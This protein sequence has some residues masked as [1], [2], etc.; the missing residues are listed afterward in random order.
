[1]LVTLVRGTLCRF[2]YTERLLASAH[3]PAEGP[4]ANWFLSPSVRKGEFGI[5]S[6]VML[7]LNFNAPLQLHKFYQFEID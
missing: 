7:Y 4:L 6:R 1:M 5:R 2:R 3:F